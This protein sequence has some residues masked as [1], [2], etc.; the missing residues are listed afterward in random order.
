MTV[1]LD[2]ASPS[3]PDPVRDGDQRTFMQD[4]I[5]AS[6]EVPI[7]VDFWATWCPP[8]QK[9]MAHNQEMLEHHGDR[10]GDKVRIVGISIDQAAPAVVKHVQAKKWEKVEH[11]HRAKSSCS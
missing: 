6:R 1:I 9:P 3:G 7:L 8:C 11:F 5:V 10:W 4:V 2:A